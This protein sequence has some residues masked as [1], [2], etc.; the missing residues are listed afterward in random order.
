MANYFNLILDT[1][2]PASP[3]VQIDG[4]AVYATQQTVNL[5]IGTSDGVTTGYQMKIWGDVDTAFDANVKATEGT[6]TWISYVTTKQIKLS[7]GDSLK[8]INVKIRDDVYNESSI[9]TDTI[10]LDTTL[11]IVSITTPDVSKVSKISGKNVCSFGFQVDTPFKEYK[12]KFVSATN[13]THDTGVQIGTTNGSTNMSGLKSDATVF[14]ANTVINCSITGA[15][16]ESANAGDGT[17]II[18]VFVRD[19]SGQWSV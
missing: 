10:N 16:L 2:A 9:A 4:G 7:A 8:T 11:P 19:E 17:K 15:D 12:V 5:T 6:S 14:A 1:T 18:K 13:A 3:T